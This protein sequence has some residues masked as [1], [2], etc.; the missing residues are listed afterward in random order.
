MTALCPWFQLAQ[1]DCRAI[2]WLQTIISYLPIVCVCIHVF[3]FTFEVFFFS[4][5]LL[6]T[7]LEKGHR[8][9]TGWIL[10]CLESR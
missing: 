5:S 7:P 3:Y 9:D 4:S 10:L 6:L 2:F 1:L 8:K